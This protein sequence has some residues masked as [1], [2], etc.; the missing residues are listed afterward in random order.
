MNLLLFTLP[1]SY[2]YFY[3]YEDD[4]ECV[5]V[6][7]VYFFIYLQTIGEHTGITHRDVLSPFIKIY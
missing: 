2:N 6:T 7:S 1:E 5:F 4:E 3:K